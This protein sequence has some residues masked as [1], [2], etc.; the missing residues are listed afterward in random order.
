[1]RYAFAGDAAFLTLLILFSVKTARFNGKASRTGALPVLRLKAQ[2]TSH[3]ISHA[4][5]AL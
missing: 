5:A 4:P 1:M 3:T 2:N